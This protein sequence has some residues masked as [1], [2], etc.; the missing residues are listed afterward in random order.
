METFITT[1]IVMRPYRRSHSNEFLS[2]EFL[3]QEPLRIVIRFVAFFI[4]FISV[5]ALSPAQTTQFWAADTTGGVIFGLVTT[6]VRRL[7]MC[8]RDMCH[9][10]VVDMT[11]STEPAPSWAGR[12]NP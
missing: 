9:V 8:R 10:S 11:D 12:S 4:K 2:N 5:V 7:D 3:F 6:V 1:M